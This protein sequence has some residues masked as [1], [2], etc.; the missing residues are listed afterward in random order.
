MVYH[1]VGLLVAK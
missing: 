1:N